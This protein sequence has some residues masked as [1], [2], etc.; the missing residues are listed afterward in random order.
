MPAVVIPEVDHLLGVRIGH[1]AQLALCEDLVA[2]V[3]LTVDLEA[4]R[5]ARVLELNRRYG[6]LALGFVDA[7]VA[8]LAEQL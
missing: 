7:A 6:D 3:Y 5:Y 1:A 8:A 2:G 4:D